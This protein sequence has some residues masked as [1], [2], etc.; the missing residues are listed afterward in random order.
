M[1][2]EGLKPKPNILHTILEIVESIE[3]MINLM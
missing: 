1:K 2:N 3:K